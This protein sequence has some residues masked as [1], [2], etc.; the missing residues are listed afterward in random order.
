MAFN[1][2]SLAYDHGQKDV[3]PYK[4]VCPNIRKFAKRTLVSV[5]VVE[6]PCVNARVE[7]C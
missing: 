4:L 5:D 3:T 1:E 2:F 7:C 6:Y